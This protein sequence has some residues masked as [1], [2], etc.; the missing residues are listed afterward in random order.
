MSIVALCAIRDVRSSPTP[1]QTQTPTQRT[2]LPSAHHETGYERPKLRWMLSFCS[3]L[4]LAAS[5]AFEPMCSACLA[6]Q[7][8]EYARNNSTDLPMLLFTTAL[9]PFILPSILR[10]PPPRPGRR[11]IRGRGSHYATQAMTA[12][13][14]CVALALCAGFAGL[15]G[16]AGRPPRGQCTCETPHE[17]LVREHR[18]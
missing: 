4:D 1:I 12:D 15:A 2:Q 5:P 11:G 17:R 7:P 18:L 16:L 10:N 14:R 3:R 9:Q 13:G 8:S 6:V